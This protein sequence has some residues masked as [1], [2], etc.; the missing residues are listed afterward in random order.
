MSKSTKCSTEFVPHEDVGWG[1]YTY[2]NHIYTY[3]FTFR[4][5]IL[6]NACSY[7]RE[8]KGKIYPYKT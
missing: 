8:G 4:Y 1:I 7:G 3:N 2:P 5:T 6:K